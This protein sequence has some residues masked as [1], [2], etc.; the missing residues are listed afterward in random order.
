MS[1]FFGVSQVKCR[2][3][4]RCNWCGEPIF[5]G[6]QA[7]VNEYKDQ[8]DE[9]KRDRLHPNCH[10][11]LLDSNVDEYKLYSQPRGGYDPNK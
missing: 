10:T 4:H 1:T 5:K 8:N 2:K 7:V 11:A 6:R 3:Q 9:F